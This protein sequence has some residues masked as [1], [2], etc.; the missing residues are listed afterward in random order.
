MSPPRGSAGSL[1]AVHCYIQP[2]VA[3]G[4][5]PHPAANPGR[6][7]SLLSSHSNVRFARSRL[8]DFPNQVNRSSR[9]VSWDWPSR[10]TGIR[11]R[12]LALGKLWLTKIGGTPRA[13][14]DVPLNATSLTWSPDSTEVAWSAG[15]ANQ[16]DLFATDL[17]TGT[18]RRITALPGR[19]VFP[20]YS[21]TATISR[22]YMLQDEDGVLRVIDAGPASLRMLLRPGIWDRSA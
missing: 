22:S 4:R 13:I 12:T 5:S 1:T 14:A 10:Q 16:E 17:T 3:C 15:M 6:S 11:L 18:T 21:P 19:E 9:G 20:A 7:L 2:T 8:H